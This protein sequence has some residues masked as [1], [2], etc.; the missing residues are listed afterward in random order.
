MKSTAQEA[1]DKIDHFLR[2][3]LYDDDYEEFSHALD[4]V[5]GAAQAQQTT[6]PELPEA[7]GYMN[8]GH[9]HELTQRRISY[10]YVYPK[11]E[12]GASVAVYTAAQMHD[13]YAAGYMAGAAGSQ[14]QPIAS[15]PKDGTKV[16]ALFNK[17]IMEAFATPRDDGPEI[18]TFGMWSGE[19][20]QPTHWMPLPAAP[21]EQQ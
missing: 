11:K 19:H 7:V 12:T 13:H 14:W 3:N 10:G 17:R 16:L 20:I 21:K 18:W 15:S 8:A 6:E 4:E 1:Y 5:L 2:N 9:V